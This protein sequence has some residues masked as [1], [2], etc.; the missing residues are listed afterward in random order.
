[1]EAIAQP[2]TPATSIAAIRIA[3]VWP[4]Y[5]AAGDVWRNAAIV[6]TRD[7]CLVAP[8]PASVFLSGADRVENVELLT[9]HPEVEADEEARRIL[10]DCFGLKLLDH[11]RELNV[12]LADCAKPGFA[13]WDGL[14]AA[15]RRVPL[16]DATSLFRQNRHCVK[17]M[18][19][20]GNWKRPWEVLLPGPIVP[21]DGSRDGSVAVDD[22]FHSQDLE[23]LNILGVVDS[24][25]SAGLTKAELD[26]WHHPNWQGEYWLERRNEYGRKGEEVSGRRPQERL[27]ASSYSLSTGPLTPYFSLSE[28]G[29]ESFVAALLVLAAK[30]PTVTWHHRTIE[31]YPNVE[32]ESPACWFI[33]KRAQIQTTLGPRPI[34]MCVNTQFDRWPNLLPVTLA[35][36]GV[37]GRSARD[38]QDTGSDHSQRV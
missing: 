35:D 27:I 25:I 13:G 9:V 6:L 4:Q 23:V 1:M 17:V 22:A 30:D 16:A 8:N 3:E 2:A 15:A 28:R 11:I 29:K 33:R 19:L 31:A 26:D 12:L 18:T 32:M 7:G 5:E 36:C 10:A 14:W 21:G 20:A 34:S 37:S 38:T 24:P